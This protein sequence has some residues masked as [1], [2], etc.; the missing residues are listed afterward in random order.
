M[1]EKTEKNLL[2]LLFNKGES[3]IFFEN[4]EKPDSPIEYRIDQ[5]IIDNLAEE[6]IDLSNDIYQKLLN[7]YIS[8]AEKYNTSVVQHILMD[9]DE[10]TRNQILNLQELFAPESIHWTDSKT[11]LCE[12]VVR[13]IQYFKLEH[14]EIIR[15]RQLECLKQ[16]LDEQL[17]IDTMQ[18]IQ[19]L[20]QTISEIESILG[21]TIRK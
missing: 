5:Y 2:K 21:V 9:A 10:E 15:N 8:S 7:T 20:N 17:L 13:T 12:E 14:L 6:E 19:N 18:K 4:E 1:L 11:K 16:P 3:L